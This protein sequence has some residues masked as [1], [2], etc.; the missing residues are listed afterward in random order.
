MKFKAIYIGI[1]IL[2]L[3]CYVLSQN[4][5]GISVMTWNIRLE[6][7]ADGINTWNNRKERVTGLILRESPDILCVQE[8]LIAQMTYLRKQLADYASAGVGR[9]DGKEQ[10][11][12][13][14]VFFNHKKYELLDKGDFWLSLTPDV[15]NSKDWDAACTR[16]CSW[17]KLKDIQHNNIFFVFNTHW[18]HIGVEART[19]SAGLI[20]EK[21]RDIA[22][23]NDVILC[24]D[25]NCSLDSKE[26]QP[27]LNAEPGLRDARSLC[28]AEGPAISYAGFKVGEIKGE[29]IDHIFVTKNIHVNKL[30]ILNDNLDGYYF[31]DHL[32]VIAGITLKH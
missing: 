30:R 15:P 11:E 4:T 32:P 25:F 20:T 13:S 19:R 27:L 6:T 7:P 8:A 16:I 10:G 17:V 1:F 21:I 14:A 31:S 3:P 18:D 28:K 23:K 2:L 26:I 22:G 12:F 29:L 24:G 5:T 9:E